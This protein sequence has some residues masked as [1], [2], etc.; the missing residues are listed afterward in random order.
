M[1]ECFPLTLHQHIS[2]QIESILDHLSL[3]HVHSSIINFHG[4]LSHTT[5]EIHLGMDMDYN[6]QNV[7]YPFPMDVLIVLE[8]EYSI[9]CI[10]GCLSSLLLPR[11]VYSE[12]SLSESSELL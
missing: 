4:M 5:Q 2:P 9:S 3:Q 10:Q 8:L 12:L 1:G 7:L 6:T 11:T